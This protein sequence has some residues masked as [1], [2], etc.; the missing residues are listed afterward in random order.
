MSSAWRE[1]QEQAAEFFHRLALSATVER[2]V[3][4]ARGVHAVDVFVEG[5]FHGIPFK[6]VVECKAWKTSVPKEKVMALAAIVQDIG[7]DRGFLLSEAGFQS[8]AVRAAHKTNITLSSLEDLSS[9]TEETFVDAAI[10]GLHWR[11]QK[12]CKR[13]RE[14]GKEIYDDDYFPPVMAPLVKLFILESALEDALKNKYPNVYR[15]EDDVRYTVDSLDELLKV[16]NEIVTEA[17]SWSP[18]EG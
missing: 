7:A 5:T 15:V 10:G 3:E 18:P 13:L 6:W 4:G 16:A 12:A 11:L 2:E 9:A 8:G 1:Y 17:E 14:I